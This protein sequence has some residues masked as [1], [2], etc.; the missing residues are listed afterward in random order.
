M[1]GAFAFDKIIFLLLFGAMMLLDLF[2]NLGDGDVRVAARLLNVKP[3]TVRTWIYNG[4]V[5]NHRIPR[6]LEKAAEKGIE[7]RRKDLA[8]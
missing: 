8:A 6:V 3:P 5:P 7:V 2:R 1:I 4:Y